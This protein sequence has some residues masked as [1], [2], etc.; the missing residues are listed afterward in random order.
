MNSAR[1]VLIVDDQPLMRQD[2]AKDLRAKNYD[3]VEKGGY[4]EAVEYLK[5]TAVAFIL[6]DRILAEGVVEVRGLAEICAV[7]GES[8]VIVYT[9]KSDVTRVAEYRLKER[10][11]IRV[12][13]RKEIGSNLEVFSRELNELLNL[14]I[15]LKSFRGERSRIV[16]ALVGIDVGVTI[17]DK[18]YHCWFAND[19]QNSIVGA[20]CSGR[21]CW[22]A[23]HNRPGDWG[24]CWGCAVTRVI[25]T[26]EEL[27]GVFLSRFH[28]DQLGWV[29]VHT[30]PVKDGET[31]AVR[32][33]VSRLDPNTLTLN[34]RLSTIAKGLLQ[35]GFGRARIFCVKSDSGT[36]EL[37]AAA[38]VHDDAWAETNAYFDSIAD[39]ANAIRIDECTYMKAVYDGRIGK[40]VG[41]WDPNVGPSPHTK[42]LMLEVPYLDLPVW[43]GDGGSLLGWISADLNGLNPDVIEAVKQ[44]WFTQKGLGWLQEKFGAQLVDAIKAEP[45]GQQKKKEIIQRA[46]MEVGGADS[47]DS[48]LEAVRKA[49]E[50]LVPNRRVSVRFLNRGELIEYEALCVGERDSSTPERISVEDK[51]SLAA[52]VARTV[53]PVWVDN[54]RLSAVLRPSYAG[55]EIISTASIPL[56]VEGIVVG[57]LSI[58][59]KIETRWADERLTGPLESL[60]RIMALVVHDINPAGRMDREDVAAYAASELRQY[61]ERHEIEEKLQVAATYAIALSKSLQKESSYKEVAARVVRAIEDARDTLYH[62]PEQQNC[63][64]H[65]VCKRYDDPAIVLCEFGSNQYKLAVPESIVSGILDTLVKMAS[66][67][68]TEMGKQQIPVRIT[69]T[70]KDMAAVIRVIPGTAVQ[71]HNFMIARGAAMLFRGGLKV[72]E[73]MDGQVFH[74]RLPLS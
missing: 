22:K 64:L 7:A 36:L 30:K 1:S 67:T 72:E 49:A 46:V 17:I 24:P 66:N 10:G 69:A 71:G 18:D 45:P 33:V 40:P 54:R 9:D 21:L 57:T 28:N 27:E 68:L 61:V 31:V 43:D 29:S 52:Y 41:A 58:D 3:V 56:S 44:R 34:I 51:R 38:S 32:E 73:S 74:L 35:L 48:A 14:S 70:I 37:M 60:A 15:G 65:E 4:L 63:H 47:V 11:A 26:G 12:I 16:A 59:S 55:E 20:E 62:S 6:L 19:Q 8:H 2:I 39:S 50:S 53:K 42:A 25:A 23:F 13:D 5:Q